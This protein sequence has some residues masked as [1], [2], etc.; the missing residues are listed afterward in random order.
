MDTRQ[1]SESQPWNVAISTSHIYVTDKSSFVKTYDRN[2]A[3]KSKYMTFAPDNESSNLGTSNAKLTGLT[4][5]SKDWLLVGQVVHPMYISKHRGDGSHIISIKI[6]VSPYFLAATSLDTIV[7]CDLQNVQIVDRTGQLLHTILPQG[8]IQYW[9]PFGICSY[10]DI[11]LVSNT[12]LYEDT[13]EISC[14]ALLAE[15]I[16]SIPVTA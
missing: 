4:L 7:V 5:D 12:H 16:G 10:Q 3:F 11:I 2:G 1:G 6:A 9:N 15:Y 8:Q 13:H 14:F